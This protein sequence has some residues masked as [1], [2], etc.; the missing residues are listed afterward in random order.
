MTDWYRLLEPDYLAVFC[1]LIAVL[2]VQFKKEWA[3]L[4]GAVF[5]VIGMV[6]YFL[7]T[8]HLV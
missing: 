6:L 8:F 2:C 5:A 3:D 4:I 1:L 7:W